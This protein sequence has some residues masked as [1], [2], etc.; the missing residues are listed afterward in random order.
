V[1]ERILRGREEIT[2]SDPNYVN[3]SK[4]PWPFERWNV[5]TADLTA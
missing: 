2:A 1:V 3:A 4:Q 5:K